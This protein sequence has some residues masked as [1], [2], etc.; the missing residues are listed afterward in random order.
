MNQLPQ[1]DFTIVIPIFTEQEN[2]PRLEH[3]LRD[4]IA[5]ASRPTCVLFVDDGS[6]DG[7]LEGI[8]RIC[9]HNAG[10]FYIGFEK[11]VGLSAAIKAGIDHTTSPL[12]GYIDADLQT[13]PDDFE[14]LLPFTAEYTLVTGIRTSRKDS[15]FKRLQSKIAN[16]WRRA[17]TGDGATDTGCP[18]MIMQTSAAK[19]LPLY[20]GKHRFLPALILLQ[21]GGR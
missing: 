4:Y 13:S 2:L 9:R 19:R 3:T 20:R 7:S 6:S 18:L 12:V 16:G 15:P 1:Y 10:F 8:I 21:D 5:K 11:N 14:R 17:M